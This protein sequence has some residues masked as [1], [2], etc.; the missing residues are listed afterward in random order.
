MITCVL[1]SG[2]KGNS[3]YIASS[4]TNILIDLG[5]SSLFVEKN[6]K[7]INVDPK[8]IE[9]IILTHTH[10]DH[11]SGIKVFI[12]KYNTKLYLTKKMF[13][14]LSKL[15]DIFNY[16]LIED[17]FNIKDIDVKVIKTSHDTSDSNG[18]IFESNGKSIVYITD[19]GYINNKNHHKLLNKNIYIMESNHDVKMLMN[20]NY[21]HH[22]KQRILGDKGHLSNKDSSYYLSKFIGKDT[23]N[24]I[25]IHISQ[26]NNNPSLALQCLKDKLNEEN[27][28]FSDITISHQN[29]RTVVFKI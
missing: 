22:L 7:E 21:P 15:F 17:D 18:Y 4:S 8:N 6:L 5:T 13:D 28:D 2:S 12:K 29:E 27:N 16:V 25:L 11:I 20:G 14:D 24:I 1:S 9:A 19:T 23:K 3:T 26:D 10:V